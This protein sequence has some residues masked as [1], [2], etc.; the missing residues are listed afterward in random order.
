MKE[1]A[2]RPGPPV[3][4]RPTDAATVS[5]T[6]A[7]GTGASQQIPSSIGQY[8]ILRPIG[9]GG[10]GAVYEAEQ[11]APHRVVALKVIKAGLATSDLLRRFE[12]EANALG[13]LQHPGIAQIFEAGTADSGS[14]PQPYFAMELIRGESLLRYAELHHLNTR[15][16]LDL[17]ARISEAVHHAHQRGIIHRDLKPSNI[18]VDQT[19]QPK[20]LD[21][22]VARVTDSDAQATRQTDLGKLVGTLAY[23]SPEQVLA[24]P[25]ELDT[26]SDVY[27]LGVILYELLADRRPYTISGKLHEAMQTIRE[28]DP[29]PLG[30]IS[31]R[32]RGDIQ[33]IVGKALEKEKGR[34][35]GSAAALASDIRHYL[36]DEPIAAQP[37]SAGYQLKKFAR[38]HKALVTSAA[39]VFTVLSGGIVAS[40]RE[41]A[42]ARQAEQTTQ[43][44]NDFL[45]NDLLAQASADVQAGHIPNPI[46]T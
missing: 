14:G 20:I 8:R 37:A 13:R 16:R 24:D 7:A 39:I 23:M 1:D 10:M 44:V 11:Q 28:E 30:S 34:R 26:R 41:A 9:E 29:A 4:D 42:R 19:G 35:Y 5:M 17:M 2:V 45:Q 31:R 25:L 43:A 22:G 32:Y 27:T 36:A 6:S 21:F 15:Q 12:Q 3:P 33:T 40:T 46:R 38:R 18:L